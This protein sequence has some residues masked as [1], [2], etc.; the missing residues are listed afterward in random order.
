MLLD[1]LYLLWGWIAFTLLV[2]VLYIALCLIVEWWRDSRDPYRQHRRALR[3]SV[4]RMR[5]ER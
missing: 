4:E 3:E 5:R 2:F 1:A